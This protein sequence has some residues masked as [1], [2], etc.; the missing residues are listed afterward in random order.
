MTR[1]EHRT[2]KAKAESEDRSVSKW[3]AEAAQEKIEREGLESKG[4]QYQIEQR[5]MAMVDDAADR[6]ADRI[7]D[8]IETETE[9]ETGGS[10]LGN[11]G[12]G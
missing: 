10:G 12:S 7:V 8:E 6:A 2:I 1:E 5:L 4:Q 3:V 9:T 11:Y